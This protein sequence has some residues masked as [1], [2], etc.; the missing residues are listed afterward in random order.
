MTDRL[1]ATDAAFLQA[2]DAS[3]PMH[4][5]GVAILEPFPAPPAEPSSALPGGSA[6][7]EFVYARIVDLI[8][9]R[10]SLVPRYR[11]RVRFVPGRLARPV[12]VDDEDFDITYHV[13]RSALPRPGTDAQLE[14][15]VGRLISRP[16][17]RERPLWEMYVIEGLSGGRIALVNKTHHAMVDRIGAVD[18]AAA[19]LDTRPS[20]RSLPDEPWLPAPAPSDI[21]LVVD[22]VA[23]LTARPTELAELVRSA[24]A[25][26]RS[27]VTRVADTA[28]DVIEIVRRTVSPAPRSVLNVRI[29]GQRRFATYRADLAA[30]KAVRSAHGGSVNDVILTVITGA[31]RS[32][33][34]ARDEPVTGATQLRAMV[35]M[36]VR[37]GVGMD[38]TSVVS[39][40]LDLP[41]AETSPVMRLHQVSFS[42]G[43]HL[44][45]GSQ[46]G[47]DA[48]V[49][50]GR[51]SPPTLHTLGARVAGQLSRRLYNVLITNVPGPQV[52]LY[53]AGLPV[54][55]MY[56]VAPLAKG[57]ALAVSCTSYDGSVFFG[58]TAD[59]DAIPDVAQFAELLGE[60]LDEL[61]A[62]VPAL[63]GAGSGLGSD[64]PVGL[65]RTAR[66]VLHAVADG[67]TVDGATRAHPRAA[68]RPG[69]QD[70]R[71]VTLR[72][73]SAPVT[74][75][76]PAGTPRR[77]GRPDDDGPGDVV[78]PLFGGGAVPP[79]DLP[80]D[81]PAPDPDP[82]TLRPEVPGPGD[83]TPREE[84]R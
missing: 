37:S 39:Y 50:L 80:E 19:I 47:A 16:L 30:F 62:T 41:V 45:S 73:V 79:P 78:R 76:D 36:S 68:G 31:L 83:R 84:P 8:S 5:G 11:Q 10:L 18:V 3:T 48:L 82:R 70:A 56:P 13:R 42:M 66:P 51:F 63:P 69:G 25:D 72:D 26:V 55:A 1:S 46:V 57:Q 67:P 34:L 32:W 65:V 14:E 43:G 38:A 64:T 49:E 4:V 35:P 52:P 2:E 77:A 61:L 12:W 27:A 40:L 21:D 17:D 7:P 74:T 22:A 20:P 81:P 53:A 28:G 33:L 44:E 23:D 71:P 24:T 59:R 9:S 75:D 60:A 58:L 6:G 15:L 54:S 29:G